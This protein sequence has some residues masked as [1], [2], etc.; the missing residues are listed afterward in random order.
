MSAGRRTPL[1]PQS[2][3]AES[4]WSRLCGIA[5]L[6]VAGLVCLVPDKARAQSRSP[7]LTLRIGAIPVP[8]FA[9]D[10]GHSHASIGVELKS[11]GSWFWFGAAEHVFSLG[12][13]DKLCLGPAALPLADGSY[14]SSEQGFSLAGAELFRAGAGYSRVVGIVVLESG[15]SAGAVSAPSPAGRY[16]MWLGA[17]LRLGLSRHLILAYATGAVRFPREVTAFGQT[18]DGFGDVVETRSEKHWGRLSNVTL[19]ARF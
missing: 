7:E 3:A 5:L 15:V 17:E 1:Q 16:H 8:V 13:D 2:S 4:G 11:S 9:R 10:C 19:G 14:R 6:C 12:G 18:A